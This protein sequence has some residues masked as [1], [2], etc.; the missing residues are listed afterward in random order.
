MSI[1]RRVLK[2]IEVRKSATG[3]KLTGYAIKFGTQAKL[4]GFTETFTADAF[5]SV[6]ASPKLDCRYLAEHDP[7]RIMGRTT[8]GTLRLWVDSV[9]LRY[10]VDL[11]DT[12]A[13][14]DLY[15]SIERGDV[16]GSS[17][18]FLCGPNDCTWTETRSGVLRTVNNVQDLTDVSA[19]TYPAYPES[20]VEA[21]HKGG[22]PSFVNRLIEMRR[23]GF[24]GC[25]WRHPALVA[26]LNPTCRVGRELRSFFRGDIAPLPDYD[27]PR[28]RRNLLDFILE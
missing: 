22:M 21:R 15:T 17:F 6:L 25:V 19:V 11:P 26:A 8:A 1:E 18:G 24:T 13:A 27:A 23:S 28:R 20:T 3:Q 2:G 16:T 7:G 9:G 5:K 12:Q 14:R 10:E 4:R